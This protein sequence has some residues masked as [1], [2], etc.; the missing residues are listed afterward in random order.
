MTQPTAAIQPAPT[1]D[2]G[3]EKVLF[4]GSPSLIPG[5]GSLLV[6]V[7]T[8]GLALIYL[9]FKR[10]GTV[11]K[12]TTQRIVVDSGIFGKKKEQIDLYRVADFTVERPFSQR[13][14]GTGNLMLNTFDKSTPKVHLE[15][16][17]TDVDQLYETLRVAVEQNKAQRGV[18]MV[19]YEDG[20]PQ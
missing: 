7:L 11:Y 15:A 12:I 6:T 1:T 9:F 10:N 14:M 17:K 19:D 3:T 20:R 8:L 5:I 18:R 2:L 16:L 13:I 4:Q